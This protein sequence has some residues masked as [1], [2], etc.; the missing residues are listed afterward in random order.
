MA[1]EDHLDPLKVAAEAAARLSTPAS[2]ML[3]YYGN[4]RSVFL[5]ELHASTVV[6]KSVPVGETF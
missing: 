1:D 2:V 3:R 4:K 6:C 5:N